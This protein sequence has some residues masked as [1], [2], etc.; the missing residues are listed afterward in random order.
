MPIPRYIVVLAYTL[1]GPLLGTLAFWGLMLNG[2]DSYAVN[3]LVRL[4]PHGYIFG[5]IPALG[6]GVAHVVSKPSLRILT[7]GLAG[8]AMTALVSLSAIA[9]WVDRLQATLPSGSDVGFVALFI[10]AKA[11]AAGG[12]TACLMAAGIEHIEERR[13]W[14]KMAADNLE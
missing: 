8:L 7:V 12:I 6:A 3:V 11:A 10:L 9:D 1:I 4:A 5:L 2:I 14:K 13:R